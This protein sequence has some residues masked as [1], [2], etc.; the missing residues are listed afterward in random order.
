MGEIEK[1]YICEDGTEIFTG[2][3]KKCENDFKIY[4]KF[5]KQFWPH[6][7]EYMGYCLRL[8]SYVEEINYPRDKGLQ[9]QKYLHRFIQ[10][11]I[12]KKQLTV[13]EICK[14]YKIGRAHV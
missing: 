7:L 3:G 2:P 11:C 9:G 14:K 4:T 10:D 12:W 6:T 5:P 8:K 13:K 1:K